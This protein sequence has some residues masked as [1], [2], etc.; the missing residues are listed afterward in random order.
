M[1]NETNAECGMRNAECKGERLA[2]NDLALKFR[3]PHSAFRIE[4]APSACFRLRSSSARR[5]VVPGEERPPHRPELLVRRAP[6][7]RDRRGGA[8]DPVPAVARLAG[9]GAPVS[10]GAYRDRSDR[11]TG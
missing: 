3:I 11:A 9:G 8:G 1:R 7:T 6:Q 4:R 2:A 10:G 5:Y